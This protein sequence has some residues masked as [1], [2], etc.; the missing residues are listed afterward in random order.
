MEMNALDLRKGNLV[1]Y[2]NRICEVIYWNILKNDRRQFV[3][4]K[5]K[6]LKTGRITELKEHG[7]SKFEALENSKVE[8]SHSY[9]DGMDEVFY[10]PEGEE[11]RCNRE[12][13]EDALKW[14]SESYQGLLVDGH[15]VSVTPPQTVT[16][17]VT[18]TSP[19]L[20]GGGSGLK[21]AMLENGI[22]VRVGL[23]VGPGDKVRIDPET[24]E[25][26]ERV[27]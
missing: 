23:L 16:L 17:K 18:E 10:T 7:D 22:K 1:R 2:E 13:A 12:A 21:D 3:Q 24:L 4:M 6:D 25:F 8:L 9:R 27:Q 15:L 19:P 20:R 26:K 14:P 11:V 5:V